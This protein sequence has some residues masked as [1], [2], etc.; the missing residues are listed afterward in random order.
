MLWASCFL[1]GPLLASLLVFSVLE[2][3]FGAEMLPNKN[4]AFACHE[5]YFFWVRFP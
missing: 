2:S 5:A 4:N 3:L 1:A